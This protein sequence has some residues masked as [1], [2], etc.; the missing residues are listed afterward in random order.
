MIVIEILYYESCLTNIYNKFKSRKND[1]ETSAK[2]LLAQIE[3][4]YDSKTL[5][6]IWV[7]THYFVLIFPV[8]RISKRL[9]AFYHH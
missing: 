1:D 3:G 4:M 5:M 7:V 8:N 9:L 6:S 2:E